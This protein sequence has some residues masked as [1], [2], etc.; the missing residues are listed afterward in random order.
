MFIRKYILPVTMLALAPFVGLSTASASTFHFNDIEGF[1]NPHL[2]QT[3]NAWRDAEYRLESTLSDNNVVLSLDTDANTAQVWAG[4][5][6]ALIDD[7]T[8]QQIG[9]ATANLDIT[10]DHIRFNENFGGTDV[11]ATGIYGESTSQG[12]VNLALDFYHLADE[13]E[14]IDIYGG[15]ADVPANNGHFGFLAGNPFNFVLFEDGDE[16]RFDFWVKSFGD[17]AFTVGNTALNLH[18][19]LHGR[20]GLPGGVTNEVPEPGT[21]VLLGMGALGIALRRRS[22]K[23]DA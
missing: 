17:D 4:I 16:F 18:G 20:T 1:F 21:V 12:T 5:D 11:V 9:V 3:G 13:T 23:G 7:Q 19:D 15:F 14:V 6:F 10:F 2:F 8:N 22:L